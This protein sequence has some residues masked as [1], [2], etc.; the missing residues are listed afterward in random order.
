MT[1][2]GGAT[3]Y[4]GARVNRVEDARLLTGRGT[5]VDDISLPGMLH[6]YF[7]R[8]PHARA[9]IRGIDASAALALTGVHAVFTAADLN[10]GVKEQWHTSIGPLSPETPRPPLADDEVRFVGDPVALVVAVSRALAQDAADLVEV[11]YEPLPAVVEYTEAEN[12]T[13]LVHENH[14]SNVVGE[15]SG[16][17]A[18]ALEDVF[19]GAAHVTT[20][21]IYQQACAAAPIEARGLIVDYSRAAGDLTIYAATQSPHEV[22]LFCS[23]LLG[24]PEHRIRV[25]MRDTGGG[26]GQK[27]MVQRDEMCL[28]LAATKV[29]A[30]VKWVEDRRENLLA[31]GKSRHEHGTVTMAFDANGAIQAAHIDFVSDCGAY[32]TPWPVGPAAA[33]GM[34][35]PGPYRVPRAGFS[36]KTVYTNTVGRTAYRGPWQFE[37]LAREVLLD[38]AAR[39]MGIDPVE[40]RRRNLLR[41][42]ELP[43]TNANGMPYDNISPTE[44]LEQALAMLDYDAFRKE[45]AEARTVGRYLGVGVSNY[46]EPSTPGMGY[47]ATEA[48]TIRIEP[49]GTINVYIAGGSTGNSIETTV[50]Q[51]TADALGAHIDDV[52]TI[53]GDTALT[54]FGAGAAGSRSGSMTAGAIRETATILRERL[55][56]IAAH[57][58]EAAVDDI[59]LSASRASVRG[60]PSIGLTLRELAE[61]AYFEPFSLPPGVPAGLEASARYTADAPIIWVNATHVCT[62]EVD[63]ETG[64][65]TLL[66]YI[67]SEDCGPMIN[68]NV[69]E[70]QIAGGVVQGIGNALFEDLAYDGEGNPVATTFIDY[71]VPSAAEVPMFEFGHI[72]TPSPGPGGYKGVGEGGA[73]GAPPAVVNAVADALSP[74]GV[75]VTRLPVSPSRIV[76]LLDRGPRP[77][78]GVRES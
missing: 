57:K 7:V 9:A 13:V 14:G 46:V 50:V 19:A 72:E 69:V 24:M 36:T 66:R 77:S 56:A 17:P 42:D 60:T 3:R 37:T 64:G 32:P 44:T 29:D 62:C 52:N 53:Q 23:R 48:A 68:P 16:L 63:V 27:I 6:A 47:Y 4:V 73:I 70:G 75:K 25:V 58:L 41:R 28:M 33:V 18:S 55:C 38:I 67:V 12:A 31:A 76:A 59:E 51:L 78:N 20:E 1:E 74:F 35:F 2:S 30:P 11:D 61:L 65:V 15:L 71:L 10:P 49:S 21:T 40:L 22:R 8:S 5:Y 26:F 54:G 43:Y 45:Q 39:E 34:L